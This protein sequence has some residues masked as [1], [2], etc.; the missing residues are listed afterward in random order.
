MRYTMENTAYSGLH[1]AN[2]VRDERNVLLTCEI[3]VDTCRL[4][5]WGDFGDTALAVTH[6]GLS[7][8]AESLKTVHE[9]DDDVVEVACRAASQ[10]LTHEI[11]DVA[12]AAEEEGTPLT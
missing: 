4:E 10:E 12:D 2:L 7:D 9:G 5:L 11:V 6:Q 8:E 1:L 3:N